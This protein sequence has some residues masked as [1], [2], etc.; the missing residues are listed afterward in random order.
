MWGKAYRSY[1]NSEKEKG[2]ASQE[3]S[4]VVLSDSVISSQK[5]RLC[6]SQG[7]KATYNISAWIFR[8]EEKQEG[9]CK[10]RKKERKDIWITQ[11]VKGGLMIIESLLTC[12]CADNMRDLQDN[13]KVK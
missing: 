13:L 11:V 5:C 10:N 12:A 9:V 7:A 8:R 1:R 3:K 2:P 6:D 4:H